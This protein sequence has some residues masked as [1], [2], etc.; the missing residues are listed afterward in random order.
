[1]YAMFLISI[2]VPNASDVT[3][4]H[5]KIYFMFHLNTKRLLLF[6]KLTPIGVY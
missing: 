6:Q 2:F 4:R 3:V 5:L 1:M